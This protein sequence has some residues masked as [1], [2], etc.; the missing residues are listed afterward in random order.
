MTGLPLDPKKRSRTKST[1]T[2]AGSRPMTDQASKSIAASAIEPLGD[3]A[4]LAARLS[5]SQALT[6]RTSIGERL[7]ASLVCNTSTKLDTIVANLD[8]DPDTADEITALLID[9]MSDL[10]VRRSIVALAMDRLIAVSDA[11]AGPPRKT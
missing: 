10:E 7:A 9:A 3:F 2:A 11:R 8:A 4:T 6:S 5:Q 1:T